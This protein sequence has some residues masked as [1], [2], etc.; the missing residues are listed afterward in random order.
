[1]SH[2]ETPRTTP[3]AGGDVKSLQG[4]QRKALRGQAHGLKPVVTVGQK[5]MTDTLVRAVDRALGTHELIKVKFIEMKEKE[6]KLAAACVLER[7]NRCEL[8]G[9]I[10]H[11]GIF[12]RRNRDPEKQR[13]FLPMT[14]GERPAP[15]RKG[16]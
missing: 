5:G 8:V 2:D 15:A 16:T 12:F 6:E 11:T 9:M 4:F 1:M 7:E 10:G 14:P 3:I 13:V